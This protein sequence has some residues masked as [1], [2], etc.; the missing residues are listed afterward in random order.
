MTTR[1][2]RLWSA[3]EAE[4]A[5]DLLAAAAP[6]EEF[7]TK[8]GR[9]KDA[10]RSHLKWID[11]AAYRQEHSVRAIARRREMPHSHI[12]AAPKFAPPPEVIADAMRRAA[13]PRSLTALFCQDPE[14]GR[15]WPDGRTA[16]Q[17]QA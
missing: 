16:E 6:P 1:R 5:R 3:A 9:T 14:P 13:V 2:F 10:S 8:L 12:V 4:I 17:V 11:D 15:R 7:I